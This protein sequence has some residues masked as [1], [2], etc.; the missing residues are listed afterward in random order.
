MRHTGRSESAAYG[1]AAMQLHGGTRAPPPRCAPGR[2]GSR[3]RAVIAARL[4]RLDHWRATRGGQALPHAGRDPGLSG[5]VGG[6]GA[7]KDHPRRVDAEGVQ[8]A[9]PLCR[10]ETTRGSRTGAPP[11]APSP[12]PAERA[13][14]DALLILW[15]LDALLILMHCLSCG[16]LMHWL[17]CGFIRPGEFLSFVPAPAPYQNTSRASPTAT[18]RARDSDRHYSEPPGCPP[19]PDH[20]IQCC[21][22]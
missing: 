1:A 12:L 8:C 17:S 6:G 19:A 13:A 16:S 14:L 15:L 11:S 18:P 10:C 3:R 20:Y 4:G 7:R 22:D 5:A 21:G 9:G 2:L